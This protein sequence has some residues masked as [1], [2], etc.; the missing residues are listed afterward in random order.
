MSEDVKASTLEEMLEE[1]IRVR[2]IARPQVLDQL[3]VTLKAL[4]LGKPVPKPKI[5]DD[6]RV[7]HAD[8]RTV[9]YSNS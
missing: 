2:P 6:L 8:G 7:L 9:R 4:T 1:S 3:N 5:N